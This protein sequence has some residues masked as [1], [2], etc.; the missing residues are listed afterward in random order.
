LSPRGIAYPIAELGG[1]ADKQACFEYCQ[2]TVNMPA[3]TLF[4][5]NNG[6]LPQQGNTPAVQRYAQA[7]LAGAAPG[8][9][10]SADACAS[11][12][13][14][15]GHEDECVSFA[16]T[17]KLDGRVLGAATGTALSPSLV[18]QCGSI[19]ACL[20]YCNAHQTDSSCAAFLSNSQ[21]GSSSDDAY[22]ASHPGPNNCTSTS[23]CN[24]Y[25]TSDT[26]SGRLAQCKSYLEYMGYLNPALEQLLAQD[27]TS[28]NHPQVAAANTEGDNAN[29]LPL[30]SD[31]NDDAYNKCITDAQNSVGTVN[32]TT[33]YTGDQAQLL[34]QLST[35]CQQQQEQQR[36]QQTQQQ[37]QQSSQQ[38]SQQARQGQEQG[39]NNIQNLQGC[40]LNALK[41]GQDIN[42]CLQNNLTQ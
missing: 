4:G 24:T 11:Y 20:S 18:S 8:A 7:I 3:C 38:A 35:L 6:L 2:E 17:N 14:D 28:Q 16:A 42:H 13:D 10:N 30:L 12:C 36:Q 23:A 31:T 22:L 33:G 26:S 21:Q 5:E 37:Q 19:D 40:L 34:S 15:A 39:A 1:C 9:C 32:P 25:C 29:N 27:S 41:A